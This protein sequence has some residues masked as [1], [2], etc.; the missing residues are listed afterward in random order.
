[1]SRR[2]DQDLDN[3]EEAAEVDNSFD[4][5]ANSEAAKMPSS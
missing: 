5:F 1:M 4:G 3:G 2:Q